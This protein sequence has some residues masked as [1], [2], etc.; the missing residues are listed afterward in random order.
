MLNMC[1]DE[2]KYLEVNT[3]QNEHSLNTGFVEA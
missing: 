1:N 3:V 2:M